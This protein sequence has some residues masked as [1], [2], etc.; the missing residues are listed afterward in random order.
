M[1]LSDILLVGVGGFLGSIARYLVHLLVKSYAASTFPLSTLLVNIFGCF[2][3]GVLAGFA[4]KI[5]PAPSRTL[6]FLGVGVL[7]GFTTFSSFGL[8]TMNLL[9]GENFGFALLNIFASVGC[10]LGA[11]WVGRAIIA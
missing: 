7:G 10:G 3:I 8:E 9:R 4:E 2:A 5:Q 6:L 11:V 1:I